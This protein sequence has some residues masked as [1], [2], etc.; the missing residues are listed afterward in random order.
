MVTHFITPE[1]SEETAELD[2]PGVAIRFNKHFIAQANAPLRV[3]DESD[4]DSSCQ[5][6]SYIVDICEF[7]SDEYSDGD[8]SSDHDVDST[9][10]NHDE[11]L[12]IFDS[13]GEDDEALE[14]GSEDADSEDRIAG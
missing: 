1:I 12:A 2:Y 6:S 3:D 5:G 11:I 10:L 8:K 4:L 9:S 7:T 14:S 13:T